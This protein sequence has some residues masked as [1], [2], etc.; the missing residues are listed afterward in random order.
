MKRTSFNG[1]YL[2]VKKVTELLSDL[3]GLISDSMGPN[4]KAVMINIHSPKQ[5]V[6]TKN[7]LDILEAIR[8]R[9]PSQAPL[10]DKIIDRLASHVLQYGDG[11]KRIV[12]MLYHF[13]RT[14]VNRRGREGQSFLKASTASAE[15]KWRLEILA[16]VRQFR[17][18]TFA[19]LVQKKLRGPQER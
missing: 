2:L 4:G 1:E 14:I 17:H 13:W 7:G 19:R 5:I 15:V 6:V 9:H 12:F 16:Q 11:T 10:V 8:G 3:Y 18:H